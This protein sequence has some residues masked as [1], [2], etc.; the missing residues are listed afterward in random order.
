MVPQNPDSKRAIWHNEAKKKKKLRQRLRNQ[1]LVEIKGGKS[2]AYII[3]PMYQWR[4]VAEHKKM[5][6]KV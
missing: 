5:D 3:P 1:F 4:E 2:I 6:K